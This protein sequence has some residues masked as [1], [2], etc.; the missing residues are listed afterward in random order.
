MVVFFPS[1]PVDVVGASAPADPHDVLAILEEELLLLHLVLENGVDAA[2]HEAPVRRVGDADGPDEALVNDLDPL[3]ELCHRHVAEEG[4]LV[5]V[6]EGAGLH[7]R[8]VNHRP[9]YVEKASVT[10]FAAVMRNASN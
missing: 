7:R 2:V 6:P 1:V 9:G 4:A 10:R 3:G 8:V 5:R